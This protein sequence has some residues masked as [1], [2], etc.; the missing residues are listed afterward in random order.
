MQILK[1]YFALDKAIGLIVFLLLILSSHIKDANCQI[2]IF[3]KNNHAYELVFRKFSWTDAKIEAESRT[4]PT[5]FENGHLVTYSGADE[6][7]FVLSIF[8]ND[9][10]GAWIGFT[11]KA[12]E[13][14]WQWIDETEGIWQDPDNFQNP[15][16]TAYTN[17][18]QSTSEP[19][20]E[21]NEDYAVYSLFKAPSPQ[22]NDLANNLGSYDSYV[23]EYDP[24]DTRIGN[25]NPSEHHSEF[26]LEENYPNPFNPTTTIRF[27]L[28]AAC[29]VKLI[30][31]NSLGQI[32]RTLIHDY[33]NPG[34]HEAYWDGTDDVGNSVSSGIYLYRLEAGEF[35][36]MKK[37]VLVR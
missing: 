37:M 9:L 28:P 12:T 20:S 36:R 8:G 16:Q 35:V 31:F 29:K 24:R 26:F 33:K 3:E 7:N 11:D 5:G 25:Q 22:W 18:R 21:G 17:W 23:V 32:V 10:N 30:I 1:L 34:F 14:E 15:I 13:G 27:Q 2:H 4:P 6:E 19:N